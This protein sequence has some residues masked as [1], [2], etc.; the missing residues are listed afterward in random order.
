MSRKWLLLIPL[1]VIVAALVVGGIA[2]L[3]PRPVS[4]GGAGNSPSNSPAAKGPERKLIALGSSISKANNLSTSLTGDHPEYSFSTGTKIGSL[5][6]YLKGKGQNLV[7]IN[8][9]ESGADSLRVFESQVVSAV[10]YEPKY[11]TVDPA[12]DILVENSPKRL[13]SNLAGIVNQ[14]KKEDTVILVS[15]YPNLIKMRSAT[16]ASC[17]EDKLR[18]GID[19]VTTQKILAFNQAIADFAREKKVIFVN[20]YDALGP[21]DV[22]DYDCVHPNIEGQKKLAKVWIEALK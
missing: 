3:R 2:A 13:I 10:G 12:S 16:F 18:V 1:V 4:E 8:I 9:A 21:G 11:V 14:L 19:K 22:S 7:A 17:K 5:Y 6:L 15:S 20:I